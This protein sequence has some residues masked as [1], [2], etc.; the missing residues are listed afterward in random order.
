[1]PCGDKTISPYAALAVV[2]ISRHRAKRP[3]VRP[4]GL[5]REITLPL[6]ISNFQEPK[7]QRYA[8]GVNGTPR[9]KVPYL[10]SPRRLRNTFASAAHEA[11]LHPLDQK[12]LMNH[13]LPR[14]GDVT[15]GYKRPSVEHLREEIERVAT[16]LLEKM[17]PAS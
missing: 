15:D 1:M 9:K 3:R 7:E 12:I 5:S 4:S 11:R 14:A 2:P 8:P 16:F 13:T 10:P 6:R 17:D